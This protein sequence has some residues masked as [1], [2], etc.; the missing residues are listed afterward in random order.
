MS[1]PEI[2]SCTFCH[3]EHE[4]VRGPCPSPSSLAAVKGSEAA[5]IKEKFL[6]WN[7]AGKGVKREAWPGHESIVFGAYRN[8]HTGTWGCIVAADF[9]ENQIQIWYDEHTR[10]VGTIQEFRSNFEPQNNQGQ[11]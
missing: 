11:P 2:D 4:V 3:Q 6:A 5:A 10:W 7:E 1:E 9:E 8:R